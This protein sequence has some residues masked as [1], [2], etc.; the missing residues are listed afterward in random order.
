MFR[1]NFPSSVSGN[2]ILFLMVIRINGICAVTKVTHHQRQ[3]LKVISGCRIAYDLRGRQI[4][5]TSPGDVG[6]LTLCKLLYSKGIKGGYLS[7]LFAVE[8]GND[9]KAKENISLATISFELFLLGEKSASEWTLKL[10]ED[11]QKSV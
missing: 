2:P 10:G 11:V 7:W 8:D 4:F 1:P 5:I 3:E 6:H 9:E